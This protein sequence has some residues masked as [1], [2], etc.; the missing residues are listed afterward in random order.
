MICDY[1]F[2]LL[3]V[4]GDRYAIIGIK[5]RNCYLV[6]CYRLWMFFKVKFVVFFVYK[7]SIVCINFY[8]LMIGWELFLDK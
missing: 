7:L 3:F 2:C 4:F 6:S 5:V 8:L 1:V